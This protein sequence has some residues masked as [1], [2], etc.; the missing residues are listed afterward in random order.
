MNLWTQRKQSK[1]KEQTKDNNDIN[2]KIRTLK[3]QSL[4]NGTHMK[5][6]FGKEVEPI[7]SIQI[8]EIFIQGT[9]LLKYSKIFT[10]IYTKNEHYEARCHSAG[11]GA[12]L[13]R[14]G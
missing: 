11:G 10:K 13:S 5:V 3:T 8:L 14:D 12:P 6:Q 9:G 1:K 4:T 2:L 7:L